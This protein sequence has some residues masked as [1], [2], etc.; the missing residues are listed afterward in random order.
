MLQALPAP[1]ARVVNLLRQDRHLPTTPY[2]LAAVPAGS[3]GRLES[4]VSKILTTRA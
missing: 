2:S 1:T 4:G 3:T